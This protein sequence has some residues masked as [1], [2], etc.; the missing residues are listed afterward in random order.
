V[1]AKKIIQRWNFGTVQPD[2]RINNEG[3]N[4]LKDLEKLNSVDIKQPV[5]SFIDSVLC[6]DSHPNAGSETSDGLLIMLQ[7]PG[8]FLE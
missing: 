7:K 2:L 1:D 5:W 4:I 3:L 6:G 8:R